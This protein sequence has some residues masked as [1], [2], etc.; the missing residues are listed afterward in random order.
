MDTPNID[1]DGRTTT[2]LLSFY[3]PLPSQTSPEAEQLKESTLAWARRFDLA[4]GDANRTDMCAAT[5]TALA[6]HMTPHARGDLAQALSDYN[7]WAW[8]VNERSD[9]ATDTGRFVA[10]LGRWE[11]IMRSP[12]SW[13]KAT[14]PLE[15][16][17]ADVFGRMRRLVSPVQW[18]RFVIGQGT[19]LYHVAWEVSLR[20]HG[21]L[22]VND[23]LAMRIGAVGTYAAA[24]YVDAVEGI[25]LSEQEWARPLV[26]A[27]AEAG[28]MV[29][30]LDNDRYSNLRERHLPVTKPN[31][32]QAVA[33]EHPDWTH[34]EVVEEVVAIRDRIMVLYLALRERILA[35]ASA[36]LQRYVTGLDL[37]ISGNINLAATASRYLLAGTEHHPGLVPEP[38]DDRLE[39]LPI[40]TFAWWWEQLG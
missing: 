16:S 3:C 32:M 39:P 24:S 11:R 4:E 21:P 36:D 40:P 33:H 15:A 31:A 27:A 23:Y 18:Q 25:E 28:I 26:R 29:G 9:E 20:G 22:P 1:V 37:F 14:A 17:V 10:E 38:S 12:G 7:A 34:A 35:D 6:T 13:P 30:A 8:A 2:R 5:G 19:W